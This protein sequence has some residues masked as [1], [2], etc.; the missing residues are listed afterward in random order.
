M[1]LA[2]PGRVCLSGNSWA[3]M[4]ANHIHAVRVEGAYRVLGRFWGELEHALETTGRIHDQK[5]RC[6]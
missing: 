2:N 5:A 4:G 3:R 6:T 1:F